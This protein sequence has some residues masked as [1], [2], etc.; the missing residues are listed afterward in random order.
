[1]ECND[2]PDARISSFDYLDVVVD[3]PVRNGVQL[4]AGV[5]NIFAKEPPVVDSLN[6]G[7]ASSSTVSNISVYPKSYDA[8]G[9]TIF[10]AVTLKD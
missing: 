2:V 9:R 10:I 7:V 4:R 6:L 5:N 3:W 1:V 8:I